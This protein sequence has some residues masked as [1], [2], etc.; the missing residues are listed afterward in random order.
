MELRHLRYFIAV[1]E[2]RHVTR[3][4][5]RL[6]IQ[7][8]PLSQQIKAL[9]R[10]LEVQLFRRKPRGVELTDAGHTFFHEARAMLAHLEQACETTRRTARGE[11]GSLFVGYTSGAAVH[12]IVSR[13]IREFRHAYPS[14]S[15]SVTEDTLNDLVERM[16]NDQIDIA[17]I[18]TAI[19]GAESLKVELLLE[20]FPIVA[21]PNDHQLA[22]GKRSN[23]AVPLKALAG[24]TFIAFGNPSSELTLQNSA[25]VTACQAAGFS[26]KIKQFVSHNLSRL[27]LVA[28]GLGVCVFPACVQRIKIGGVVYLRLEGA[29]KFKIPL[30]LVFRKSDPSAVVQQF[31]KM[32]RRTGRELRMSGG[33]TP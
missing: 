17:F 22:R 5:E 2:E 27:N 18:R 19:A 30:N 7:Q 32:V 1:A 10:E 25:L 16:R 29:A 23:A 4:A 28:A 15:V 26:P 9:E 3:A 12:P 13:V 31:L 33:K 8:P 14:V 21:I 11:Q 20:E 24:E 6:G